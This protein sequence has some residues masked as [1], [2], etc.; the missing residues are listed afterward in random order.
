MGTC[1]YSIGNADWWALFGNLACAYSQRVEETH[2][3]KRTNREVV[4][5][6]IM[7]D[8]LGIKAGSTQSPLSLYIKCIN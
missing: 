3:M 5:R 6:H 7:R 4:K 1:E 8:A 2:G